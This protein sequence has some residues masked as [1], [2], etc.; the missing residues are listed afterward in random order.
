[1]SF[2]FADPVSSVPIL[3]VMPGPSVPARKGSGFAATLAAAGNEG[4][5]AAASAASG[6]AGQAAAPGTAIPPRITDGMTADSALPEAASGAA[7]AA[8]TIISFSSPAAGTA[9]ASPASPA[10]SAEDETGAADMPDAADSGLADAALAAPVPPAVP[11]APP[12]AAATAGDD[13]TRAVSTE[14]LPPVPASS[15]PEASADPSAMPGGPLLEGRAAA[16]GPAPGPVPPASESVP[17]APG[18]TPP[19]IRAAAPRA[20]APEMPAAPAEARTA[21]PPVAGQ[22]VPETVREIATTPHVTSVQAKTAVSTGNGTTPAPDAAGETAAATP[23]AAGSDAA[24]AVKPAI[25]APEE[26][27]V[28][29]VKTQTKAADAAL[30]VLTKDRT[31]TKPAQPQAEKPVPQTATPAEEPAPAEPEKPATTN[32]KPVRAADTKPDDE[33]GRAKLAAP[34]K[35]VHDTRP[36][37]Q[38]QAVAPNEKVPVHEAVAK[39]HQPV[40]T[41]PAAVI[42][43]IAGEMA[44]RF[45]QGTTQFEIRLDPPE[46]GRVDV[47]IEI[48][49]DGRVVSRLTVE[50][51]ETLD[52]LKADQRA[53]ERALHEAGFKSEQNSL[54]FTLRDERGHGHAKFEEQR[55][56]HGPEA[57][58]ETEEEPARLA[59]GMAYRAAPYSSGGLDLT[60]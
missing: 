18:L 22:T 6:P 25:P 15:L 38:P 16:A 51:S 31:A 20:T 47:R 17:E 19:Q 29:D 5:Q 44:S 28:S 12:V 13:D 23:D 50:K 30:D 43:H 7:P 34:E 42:P 40:L 14:G 49:S 37:Q 26:N 39:A 57:P 11:A 56:T 10:T 48:D 58:N 41:L 9:I 8:G 55:L 59:A 4:A 36:A 32:E 53:L 60:V 2:P 52:L 3:P 33:P 35:P 24:P 45:K 21:V 54:S 46:L 27:L 1:M